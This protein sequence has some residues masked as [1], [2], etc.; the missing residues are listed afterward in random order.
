MYRKIKSPY[1]PLSCVK[2]RK[3][4]LDQQELFCDIGLMSHLS[5]ELK[6]KENEVMQEG[7]FGFFGYLSPTFNPNL[8]HIK[9]KSF[10]RHFF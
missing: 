2:S 8:P 10:L 3:K 7:V 1:D 6:G 4:L 9:S 5:E